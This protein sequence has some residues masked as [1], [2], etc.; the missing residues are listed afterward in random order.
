VPSLIGKI[1][2]I[3]GGVNWGLV[4][5]GTLLSSNWNVVELLLG[6][7]PKVEAIV[8]ILVGIA[9]VMS[10]FGCKCKKC[11]EACASCGTDSKEEG[12]M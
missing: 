12:S 10:I 7:W 8:Y 11:A 4:G 1:L 5:V 6:S 3:V 9:A 2:L